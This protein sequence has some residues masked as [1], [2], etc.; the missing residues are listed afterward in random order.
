VIL[1]IG[2]L[3][4]DP[5]LV[6]ASVNIVAATGTSADFDEFIRRMKN[7]PTPQEELRY[8]GALAEFP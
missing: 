1:D 7:A 5:A 6:A 3:E 4:P 8:L 2:A